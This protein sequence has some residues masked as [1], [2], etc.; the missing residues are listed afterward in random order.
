MPRRLRF[1]IVLLTTA[2][3]GAIAISVTG[4]DGMRSRHPRRGAVD[5]ER[6]EDGGRTDAGPAPGPIF[7]AQ[8]GDIQI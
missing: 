6:T 3:I 7:T 5:D 8:P 4:C 1:A 2:C